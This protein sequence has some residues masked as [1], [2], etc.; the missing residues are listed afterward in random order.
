MVK[1]LLLIFLLFSTTNYGQCLSK[2]QMIYESADLVVMNNGKEYKIVLQRPYEK[3]DDPTI[4]TYNKIGDNKLKFNR[5][6]MIRGNN[7]LIELLEWKKG[8]YTY[9]ESREIL[10]INSKKNITTIIKTISAN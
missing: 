5:L 7:K 4:T 10:S 1:N 8:N 6:L 9:Y 2:I 3:V